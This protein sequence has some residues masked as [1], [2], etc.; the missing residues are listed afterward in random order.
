MTVEG[1]GEREE[2]RERREKKEMTAE[3]EKGRFRVS[4]ISPLIFLFYTFLKVATLD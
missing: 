2:H 1:E 3:K 4:K